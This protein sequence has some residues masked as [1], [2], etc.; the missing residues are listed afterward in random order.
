MFPGHGPSMG[1]MCIPLVV[2]SIFHTVHAQM[3]EVHTA[4]IF[5]LKH[6]Q[7]GKYNQ[8]CRFV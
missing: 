8:E 7:I 2:F 6:L 3:Q 5:I 4:A 1:P